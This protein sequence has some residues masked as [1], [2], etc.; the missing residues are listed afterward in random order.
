MTR[1]LCGW[2]CDSVNQ[3]QGKSTNGQT[4][5]QVGGK[6]IKTRNDHL[7]PS[8]L[9]RE[10]YE[11]ALANMRRFNVVLILEMLD[12]GLVQLAALRPEWQKLH[13]APHANS[14]KHQ[15]HQ[16][17]R[18]DVDAMHELGELIH[19]DRM[20]YARAMNQTIEG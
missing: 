3:L 14:A 13:H 7:V 5:I 10:H 11:R 18:D 2:S 17:I 19:Y 15:Q 12:Q 20:L 16:D 4:L 1:R 9:T 6:R 8:L